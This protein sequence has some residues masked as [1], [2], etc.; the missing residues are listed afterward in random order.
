MHLINAGQP[1]NS[2]EQLESRT[3][4]P[5]LPPLHLMASFS[6]I[7]QE[8]HREAEIPEEGADMLAQKILVIS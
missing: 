6:N 2:P 8:L 5:T 1:V 4:I 3:P 7:S